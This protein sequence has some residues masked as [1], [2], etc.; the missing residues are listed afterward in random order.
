[1][2]R[3]TLHRSLWGGEG[4]RRELLLVEQTEEVG[5]GAAREEDPRGLEAEAQRTG[6]GQGAG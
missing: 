2:T 6:Q 3:G 1:M 5:G 4:Q